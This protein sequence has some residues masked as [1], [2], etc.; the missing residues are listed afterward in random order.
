MIKGD[1]FGSIE[2]IKEALMK[3]HNS[4]VKVTVVSANVGVITENDVNFASASDVV[5]IGFKVQT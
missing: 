1:V 5:I 3:L 4:E 2:A